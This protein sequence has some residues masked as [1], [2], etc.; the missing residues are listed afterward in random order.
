MFERFSRSLACACA[1]LSLWA[2]PAAAADEER[3]LPD[4]D[5]RDA[6]PA[7]PGDV[8]LWV[9]R[10]VF[11]P[12]YLVA[13]YLIRAPLG[14]II[15]GAERQGVPAWLYDV[16]TFG[17]EHQAGVVPTVYAD[18]DF[19]PSLGL[20]AF[21]DNAFFEHHDLRVRAAIGGGDWLVASFS[22]RYHFGA[23]RSDTVS[24]EG[25]AQRRPDYTFFGIGP[26]TRQD[27]LA[28]YGLGYLEGRAMV[29][30]RPWRESVLHAQ[31]A[32]RD[33]KFFRGGFSDDPTL[34]DLV[35]AGDLQL[36]P[37]YTEGYTLL[38]GDFSASFD[39]RKPRPEPGSGVRVA[40]Q[41]VPA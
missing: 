37:A 38:S 12:V 32:L 4:Y 19:Y 17:S 20:Y 5:G 36:P 23:D 8:L 16:F 26:D 1:G 7:T 35:A 13:E 27:N 15:A 11:F 40:V 25:T 9:P 2:S 28:R 34:A 31:V 6:P 33:S 29:D 18:F 14:F 24:L 22:E 30:I 10:I 39:S 3:P 41:A 21:W